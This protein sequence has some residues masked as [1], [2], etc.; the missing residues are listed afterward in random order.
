MDFICLGIASPGIW[1]WYLDNVHDRKKITA[2][3]FKSKV[4]GWKDWHVM[5]D[6]DGKRTWETNRENNYMHDFCT[7]INTRPSCFIC[8]FKGIDHVSDFTISDCWGLGESLS[9][10]DDKGLSALLIHSQKGV[11]LFEKVKDCFLLERHDAKE[12]MLNNRATFGHLYV[13]V[14]R[15]EFFKSEKWK[16]W[17]WVGKEY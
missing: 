3:N 12:L 14:N 10:N 9:I 5:F 17:K 6:E 16:E 13:N 8:P 11:D 2:I 15:E 7:G 4:L 1:E